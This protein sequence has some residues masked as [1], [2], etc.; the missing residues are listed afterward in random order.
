M[1]FDD[2][3][4]HWLRNNVIFPRYHEEREREL[5]NLVFKDYMDQIYLAKGFK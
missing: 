3:F 2:K 5:R 1:S 4:T